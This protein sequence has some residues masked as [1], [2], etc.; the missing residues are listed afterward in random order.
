MLSGWLKS[1]PTVTVPD[2]VRWEPELKSRVAAEGGLA[3]VLWKLAQTAVDT[4]TVMVVPPEIWAMSPEPIPCTLYAMPALEEAALAVR[5]SKV[6]LVMDKT[7]PMTTLPVVLIM[8]PTLIS[9][10]NEVPDP[11]TVVEA[12]EVVI[13]PVRVVLG[14]AVALQLPEIVDVMVAALPLVIAI[15]HKNADTVKVLQNCSTSFIAN[16]V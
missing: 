15:K 8:F 3:L 6:L 16:R 12:L 14:Q 10:R 2:T 4:S 7:V 11:V 9:V 5:V 1:P 13:V